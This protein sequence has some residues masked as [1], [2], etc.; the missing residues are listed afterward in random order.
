MQPN[1]VFE[2]TF[3]REKFIKNGISITE[4]ANQN[5]FPVALVYQIIRGERK[6]LR[7]MSHQ[8]AIK[9]GIKNNG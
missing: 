8:I 5:N 3:V 9:L 6:C 7:G 2:N 1:K 4:W